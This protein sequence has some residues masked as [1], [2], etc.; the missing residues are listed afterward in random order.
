MGELE[1]LRAYVA[2]DERA[3]TLGKQRA[4]IDA[5][6]AIIE[7]QKDALYRQLRHVVEPPAEAPQHPRPGGLEALVEKVK[8]DDIPDSE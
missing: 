7:A 4:V 3:Y 5:E 2:A 8:H 1:I 6:L